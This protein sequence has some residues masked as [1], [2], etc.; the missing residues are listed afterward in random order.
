MPMLAE[1]RTDGLNMTPEEIVKAVTDR[2]QNM[3]R[4][5]YRGQA[6]AGWPLESG[7][8]HRLREAHGEDFPEEGGDLRK[9]V[10]E[11]HMDELI[12]PMQIVGG[13]ELSDLQRLSVLQHQGA[14]TGFLDFTENP[15]VALWFASAD[16]SEVDARIFLL[17]IGDPRVAKNARAL[18]DPFDA[19][20]AY[21]EPERSLGA[22]IVAQQSVF[23]IC[24]PSVP[25]RHLKSVDVPQS[26]KL[27]LRDYL[28]RLG[29][30][31]TSLFADV[32][33]LAAANTRGKPLQR[34]GPVPP[35]LH[36]DRG[37][38]AY[39]EGRY[40]DALAAYEAYVAALPDV[41]QPHCLKGDTLAALGRFGEANQAYTSAI[42]NVDRPLDLGKRVVV[43]EE[44]VGPMMS[45]PLHYNRGNVRAAVGNHLD[46]VAD[47]DEALRLRGV[48]S[49]DVLKNRG[50][51]KFA[52]EQFEEAYEDF[53]AAW[54]EREGADAALGMGN[55]KV[56]LG[57]FEDAL[58][59]FLSGAEKESNGSAAHCRANADQVQ[60]VIETLD[61]RKF[62]IRRKGI[63]VFVEVAE[64]AP[65]G[66]MAPNFSFV[67]NQGNAGNVP[68]GMASA[69]GGKGYGRAI[70]F[71]VE[72][73]PPSS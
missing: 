27:A 6:D 19:E 56:I 20:L 38:R 39:Q 9:L 5:V 61:G 34:R 46:A 70:W 44:V 53:E 28:T 59:R 40:D 4:P 10:S 35:E 21:Y 42:E 66:G 43:N 32:P 7:A 69:S 50:N 37:H 3:T 41:A 62:R 23:V 8:V 12:M 13:A 55:C 63:L 49:R 15:L 72:I 71:A 31:R 52:L 45:G 65:V 64:L 33:G 60:G 29:M 17:D 24:N 68:C 58:R 48:A 25:E 57:E 30:S 14:G 73:V 18:E 22:R 36:R 67:G 16:E 1:L 47:F 26:S 51:S 2:S 54:L 11:Y